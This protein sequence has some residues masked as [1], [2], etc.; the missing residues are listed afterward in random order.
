MGGETTIILD[1][2]FYQQLLSYDV[3]TLI[4]IYDDVMA[5]LTPRQRRA[6]AHDGGRCENTV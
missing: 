3:T 6:M 5:L 2:Y 1:F 4:Y